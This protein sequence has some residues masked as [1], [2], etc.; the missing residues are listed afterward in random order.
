MGEA[1][2]RGGGA[3]VRECRVAGARQF[4]EYALLTLAASDIARRAEPGQF[5][6]V[7]VPAPGFHLRRPISVFRVDADR[8][9]ILV[10]RRG[11]GSV[12]IADAAVG[13][14]LTVNGPIGAGFPVAGV[15]KGLL[16]G[17]GIGTAPLQ[18][19]ADEL[20]RR[21]AE[22]TS[23]FGF[24]DARAARLT[25]AFDLEPLYLATEDGSDGL[26]GTVMD[27]LERLSV[28]GDAV[29]Y[30]CGPLAML[31]A[32]QR[33]S[34]DRGLSGYASLEAHMACGSGICHGCVLP[35]ARGYARVC[36]D[37]PVLPLD[38]LRF[39]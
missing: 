38:E 12:L 31:A 39:P 9:A 7:S 15:G 13:D 16:V 17:G 22:V 8:L 18:F 29:V 6:M 19:L 2:T 20:R 37:G 26:R 23:V 5:V 10:E 4:G 36:V 27:L 3:L 1:A 33:W 30:A 35:T 28:P 25:A 34:A 11:P 21:G 14:T 32:L 24:R